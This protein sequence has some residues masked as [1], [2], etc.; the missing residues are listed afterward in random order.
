MAESAL[1]PVARLLGEV[2]AGAVLFCL[3]ILVAVGVE[4][5]AT[6]LK[7]HAGI[8]L[9]LSILM[10]IVEGFIAILDAIACVVYLTRQAIDF[11]HNVWTKRH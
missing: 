7:E 8:S 2:V 1:R 11:C 5:Y 6:F 4:I 9:F 10:D 3:I